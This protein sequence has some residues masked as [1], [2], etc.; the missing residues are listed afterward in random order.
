LIFHKLIKDTLLSREPLA[1]RQRRASEILLDPIQSKAMEMQRSCWEYGIHPRTDCLESVRNHA[2][3]QCSTWYRAR[4]CVAVLFVLCILL[5]SVEQ[6]WAQE[7][8]QQLEA[9]VA[10]EYRIFD[11]DNADIQS[12]AGIAYSPDAD[13]FFLLQADSQNQY[14]LLSMT[15]YENVIERIAVDVTSSSPVHIAFD[16]QGQRLLLLTSDALLEIPVGTNGTLLPATAPIRHALSNLPLGNAQ[17]I[18]VDAVSSHLYI[19][20]GTTQSVVEIAPDAQGDFSGTVPVATIALALPTGVSSRG[21]ARN[22]TTGQLYTLSASG[23]TAYEFSSAGQLQQTYSLSDVGLTNPQALV[24]APTAD[25]TDDP[26]ALDL[27]VIDSGANSSTTRPATSAG[28]VQPAD[29]AADEKSL[30]LFIPLVSGLENGDA[31]IQASSAR[32]IELFLTP[33]GVA[34]ASATTIVATLVR[35]TDMSQFTPPSPDPSGITYMSHSNTLFIADGEVDEMNIFEGDNLFETTLAGTLVDSYSSIVTSDRPINN[36]PVGVTYAAP[37]EYRANAHLFISDDTSG[38][39]IDVVDLGADGKYGTADDVRAKISTSA[40]SSEDPEGL[41]YDSWNNALFIADGLGNE[42]YRI[43]PGANGRFD[44]VTGGGGD[45]VTHF[46]V[47][48]LGI[49]DPEGI[50]FNPD[51][52]H[53]YILSHTRGPIAELLLDG[54]LVQYIDVTATNGVAVAGLAYGPSSTNPSQKHLYIV[55]RGVDNNQN[56]NENDGKLYELSFLLVATNDSYITDEDTV[57][58]VADSGVLS[59]DTDLDRNPLTAVKVSNPAHGSVTFDVTGSFVYTPDANFNG[60]DSF[61]YKA[62]DGSTDSNIATVTITIN[63]VNDAPI[64]VN[65]TYIANEDSMLNITA[66]NGVLGNDSDVDSAALAAVKVTNPAHGVLTLNAN[67][68]FVYTPTANYNGLDSFTYK[69]NDGLTDSNVATVTI[70][71]NPVNDTPVALNDSRS[72]AEN[73]VLAVAAPGVLGNDT[74]VEGNSLTAVKVT[75]PASGSLALN[76][77][78]AFVYTPDAN[79]NGVDSF[80]YKANDGSADSNIATVTI[81]VGPINAVPVAT[82][83][84]Y[85]VSQNGVL[86]IPAPGVLGNDSDNDNASLTAVKVSEPAHG[87]LTLNANGSFVYTPTANYN[88]AD[89]FTY[90][91]KDGS[92]DSNIATVTITVALVNDAPMAVNNSYSVKENSVLKMVAPGVLGNDSD[93]NSAALVAVKGSDPAHG[94]LTL[95]LDGSFVYTPTAN[96]NGVDSFT[97]K[98]SDGSAD[99]NIATVTITINP[100]GGPVPTSEEKMFLPMLER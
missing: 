28:A 22:D 83:D 82:N 80:T 42:I 57:L 29:E 25:N 38:S 9:P 19:L 77:N 33:R 87:T 59:N 41:A 23:D 48:S 61:T 88:G 45:Q 84:S 65:D 6:L 68:S 26:A 16:G 3:I 53:L 34:M 78:G 54:T 10:L 66:Q 24:L 95:N 18:T 27:F 46:D 94:T 60:V 43:A 76:A 50:E 51:N 89:S 49:R 62:N 58:T 13:L 39:W 73:G 69:D 72:I 100:A 11:N 67:G 52:G 97:Y 32:V 98:A 31:P 81:T 1:R 4:Q 20:D 44:G 14:E 64:A 21:L 7:D 15:P 70:T 86:N 85:N 92:A 2:N 99:S 56:A 40:F 91:A 71:I 90:F 12:V 63:P 36:E 35:T 93:T 55:D 30:K 17:G 8:L 75:D 96:F 79:F 5:L 37:G 47:S 74:D